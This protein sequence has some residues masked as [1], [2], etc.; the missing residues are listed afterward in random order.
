MLALEGSAELLQQIS[1][2]GFIDQWHHH[3]GPKAQDREG[4]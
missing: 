3:P 4:W 1:T 2:F